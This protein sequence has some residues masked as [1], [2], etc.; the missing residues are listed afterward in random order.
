[1]HFSC[2]C[3]INIEKPARMFSE[4]LSGSLGPQALNPKTSTACKKGSRLIQ[5]T[6][7]RMATTRSVGMQ[8]TNSCSKAWPQSSDV[9]IDVFLQCPGDFC[10]ASAYTTNASSGASSYVRQTLT[11]VVDTIPWLRTTFVC[12]V[13]LRDNSHESY[14]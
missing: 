5:G 12:E 7:T 8:T 13:L 4:E 2:T 11:H 9:D 14:Q 10:F 6:S 1:M 3:I